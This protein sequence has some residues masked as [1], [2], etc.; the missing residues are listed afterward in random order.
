MTNQIGMTQE[1][2]I[3]FVTCVCTK[4]NSSVQC[5]ASIKRTK[6]K[7]AEKGQFDIVGKL[8]IIH[9]RLLDSLKYI[10]RNMS[11]NSPGS[12]N[13]AKKLQLNYSAVK[14]IEVS[15]V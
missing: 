1:P 5:T 12:K 3:L 13:S 10:S 8:A 15:L 6:R 7:T 4:S 14:F 9:A 2:D 11:Q